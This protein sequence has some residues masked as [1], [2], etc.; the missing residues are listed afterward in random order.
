[1]LKILII[2]DEYY[3]RQFLLSYINWK[4]YGCEIVGEASDGEEG[5]AL[6]EQLHPDIVLLDINMPCMNGIEFSRIVYEKKFPVSLIIISGHSEFEYAQQAIRY[7]VKNYLLKPIDENDLISTL[8]SIKDE[9]DK[10]A[11]LQKIQQEEML[12]NLIYGLSFPLKDWAIACPYYQ[13]LVIEFDEQI[14]FPMETEK[15]SHIR[16][17]IQDIAIKAL[18]DTYTLLFCIDKNHRIVCL[19]G[20]SMLY[21]LL[22]NHLQNSIADIVTEAQNIFSLSLTVGMGIEVNSIEHIK[23]SYKTAIFSIQNRHTDTNASIV[24]YKS[25]K[26]YVNPHYML[27]SEMRNALIMALRQN[28]FEKIQCLIYDLFQKMQSE[29]ISYSIIKY[30]Y[31]ELIGICLEYLEELSISPVNIFSNDELDFDHVFDKLSIESAQNNIIEKYQR[32]LLYIKKSTVSS[33]AKQMLEIT[34]YI[35]L[36]F[37]DSEFKIQDIADH[38][39]INYHY[40]CNRFKKQTGVTLNQYITYKRITKAK[41]L[42]DDGYC[43]IT[44]LAEMVG[45]NELGYFGKCF[46]KEVGISPSRYIESIQAQ[47]NK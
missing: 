29:K 18:S 3:F 42:M 1:M 35:E 26:N 33:S 7:G 37:C 8:Y 39:S 30:H 27:N 45:Y 31:S 4:D 41:Q 17:Q 44:L 5:M 20:L 10:K 14:D 28:E 13:I 22:D 34:Q 21:K 38:F 43:N 12:S 16:T 40:L 32:V 11:Q 47:A 23:D 2:D 36:H 19:L 24:N 6:L 9:L 46:K 15:Y 25:I